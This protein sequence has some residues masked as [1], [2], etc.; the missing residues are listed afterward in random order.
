MC[1]DS[2]PSIVLSAPPTDRNHRLAAI[3]FR[4][5][6]SLNCLAETLIAT[7]RFRRGSCVFPHFSHATLADGNEDF[8]GAELL[9]RRGL[10]LCVRAKFSRPECSLVLN[11]ARPV[12]LPSVEAARSRVARSFSSEECRRSGLALPSFVIR[13]G[14][15]A[16]NKN[17]GS[18]NP[19]RRV[20]LL[21]NGAVFENHSGSQLI[22]TNL[23][24]RG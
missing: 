18:M 4:S 19:E 22:V 8:V 14:R 12:L 1:I 15:R 9:A 13:M 6:R 3:S 24:G 16:S 20:G 23:R 10:H 11:H 7:S 5:K 2:Y 21:N 17:G